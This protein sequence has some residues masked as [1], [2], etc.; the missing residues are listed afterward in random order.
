MNKLVNNFFGNMLYLY[1]MF[2]MALII[3]ASAFHQ[4]QG[5]KPTLVIEEGRVITGN[6]KILDEASVVIAGDSILS[7]AQQPVESKGA[8]TIDASGKTILPGL[9][10]AHVHLTIPKDGR[11]S[12]SVARH[13]KENIPGIL[14][15]YLEQGVT[16]LRSIGEYWPQ[17]RELKILLEEG[18][19]AGPRM[20]TS[21][22]LL[23]A[24][25]GHP[26]SSVCSGQGSHL[27]LNGPQPYCRSHLARE[28]STP[29]KARK[30]IQKLAQ[31]GVD[32]IKMVSDSSYGPRFT[33][34]GVI[35]AA[36]DQTHKEDLRAVGHVLNGKLVQQYT[37]MG[38]DGFAHPFYP[39]TAP[40]NDFQQL[41][42]L[43]AERS[44]PVT[45][46]LSA[47]LLFYED[48]RSKEEIQSILNGQVSTSQIIKKYARLAKTL[49]DTGVPVVVG[50]DWWGGQP[51]I[52]PDTEP[53]NVM[54]TEMEMLT[55]GGLSNAAIIRGATARA[56]KA[57]EMGDKLGT[58]ERGKLADILIVD[59]NP[60]NNLSILEDPDVV[61]QEGRV[62]SRK[63]KIE[64]HLAKH[65]GGNR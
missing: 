43:L 19:L 25:G 52:H 49:H 44:K 42:Q 1:F 46:T 45:T 2:T 24:K 47:A 26:V 62:V 36:I 61:I 58:L 12:V 35:R 53:G 4:S 31:Q 50:T 23:T 41:S 21:G 6:G 33:K 65:T 16:T 27:D 63:G 40:N 51:R 28:V 5:Q 29:E 64:K 56:A 39:S 30:V 32:Y 11:D 8:R 20:I 37:K 60:L 17:A 10:D 14:S 9:I 57:L 3:A 15:D 22:P 18:K 13:M 54:I 34:P 38:I 7:V 48:G 55:W 59:G